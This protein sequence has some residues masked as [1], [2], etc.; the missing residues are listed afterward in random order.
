M[1]NDHCPRQEPTYKD[2]KV[3]E[4]KEYE[5]RVTAIN[6]AGPSEPSAATAPV[7]AKPAKGWWSYTHTH[8]GRQIVRQT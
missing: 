7:L 2:E 1:T 3:Q 6:A 8:T 5:Y 4:G